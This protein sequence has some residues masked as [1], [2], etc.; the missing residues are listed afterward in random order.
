[1]KKTG[2]VYDKRYQLHDTGDYHPEVAERLEAVYKGIEEAGLLPYLTLI[3]AVPAKPKWIEAVHE[4]AYIRRFEELCLCG[5]RT[6]DFP[7]NQ[8]CCETYEV[9]SLAVGGVLKAAEMMMKG[10]IDNAFCAVRPPGHHA[11]VNQAMGFCYFNN[12]A[13]CARYLQQEWGIGRIGIFD[14]DVHHGNGT[15]HIFE[16][17]ATVLYY[18]VHE[19]PSFAFPGTGRAFE[20][21][22][23]TGTGY[24]RNY[25]ILP[26]QGDD[27]YDKML[28]EDFVPAFDEFAPEVILVSAGFDAHEDDDMSGIS[29]STA[30]FSRIMKTVVELA[31]RHAGGRLISVL[32]GGYSIRRLPELAR[33]HIAILLGK[34][35]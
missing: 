23:G 13:I 26:G 21:G 19:H 22:T 4:V 17:D 5:R 15:Q 8:M 7:D 6:F 30:G 29:L 2:F 14:F 25:P 9:A 27:A 10:E 18:S 12:I 31:E 32:E 28:K 16:E 33:D 3:P 34:D 1:M 11:E 20:K 24:T 35:V